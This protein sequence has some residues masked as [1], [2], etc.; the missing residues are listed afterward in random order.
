M[1]VPAQEGV[2][3]RVLLRD[4]AYARLRDAILDGTL[5]AG[6]QLRDV[7]L[8][9]WLGISRTPIREALARL[10]DAGLVESAP[11]RYTRVAPLDRRDAQDAF[12]VV[13]ALQALAATLGVAQV[14]GAELDVMSE[15]NARFTKA[16]ADG[17][18]DAAIAADDAFHDVLVHASANAEIAKS[19]ERLMPRVRR[20]ERVRFGS[21]TGR[22]SVEQHAEIVDRCAAGDVEGAAEAVRR[23]WLSLGKL[24]D[25]SFT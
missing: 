24:I 13:A 17:D 18:V 5:E 22:R 12:Q 19:L 4:E 14:S 7:E 1:P 6:E 10:E 8:S 2:A 20:L 23:N 3:A 11:N 21:L 9:A 16:L 15:A 25:R